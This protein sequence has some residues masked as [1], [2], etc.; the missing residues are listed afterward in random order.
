MA[1]EELRRIL[2]WGGWLR[3]SHLCI[4][5]SVIILLVTGWLTAQSPVL[6]EGALD[7]HFLAASFLLFGLILRIV[8]M[9]FGQQNERIGHLIPRRSELRTIG[10]TALFYLSLGRRPLPR[11]FDHSPLWKLGYL[12]VFIALAIQVITGALM[13]EQL[14]FHGFYLPSIHVFWAEFILWF[15]GLHVLA[16]VVHD[17]KGKGADVS[18]MINGFRL[19]FIDRSQGPG[20]SD[21]S[22]QYVSMDSLRPKDDE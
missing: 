16:V 13:R 18:G 8:L 5:A 1:D 9:V 21:P 2:V 11:W 6:A 3:L 12:L 22:V 15:S 4:G 19:F 17:L 20:S 14:L 7:I 10:Q